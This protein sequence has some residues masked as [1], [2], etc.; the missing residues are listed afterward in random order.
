[1]EAEVVGTAVGAGRMTDPDVAVVVAVT[2][3]LCTSGV[4]IGTVAVI[5]WSC[6]GSVDVPVAVMVGDGDGVDVGS[7][8]CA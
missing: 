1:V 5:S 4:V 7:V 8:D 6:E 3:I 2:V